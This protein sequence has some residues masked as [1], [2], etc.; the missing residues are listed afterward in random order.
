MLRVNVIIEDTPGE[1]SLSSPPPHACFALERAIVMDN[2]YRSI[3]R[4]DPDS[5]LWSLSPVFQKMENL[6]AGTGATRCP[7]DS[8]SALFSPGH[9]IC[10][11]TLIPPSF[12][13]LFGP[14]K[15]APDSKKE[16]DNDDQDDWEGPDL[17]ADS[18][19]LVVQLSY[20][21]YLMNL[22]GTSSRVVDGSSPSSDV[23]T[24]DWSIWGYG[25]L[26]RSVPSIID[27]L[28]KS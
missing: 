27:L 1:L 25:T 12:G 6:C 13:E 4:L 19:T 18:S 14:E 2:S 15:M 7:D 20:L 3:Y 24:L 9:H 22:F 5:R 21:A 28:L 16:Q 17:S 10:S 23:L 26:Y 11:H 8:F